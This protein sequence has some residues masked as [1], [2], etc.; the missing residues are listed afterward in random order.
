[1]YRFRLVRTV[2]VEHQPE[3]V[4][5]INWEAMD[6]VGGVRGAQPGEVVMEE[7]FGQIRAPASFVDT[8]RRR[9]VH[10]RRLTV[11]GAEECGAYNPLGG[12]DVVLEQRRREIESVADIVE[13][14]G[15]CV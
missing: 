9:V 6:E 13:P 11:F 5:G 14:E 15:R 12:I 7:V 3:T 2:P 10:R 1:M 8:D 4:F